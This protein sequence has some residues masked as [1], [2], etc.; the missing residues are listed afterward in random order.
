M[1]E[2]VYQWCVRPKLHYV[3]HIGLM[4]E[5]M[6]PKASWAYRGEAMVGSVSSLAHSCLN[7]TAPHQVPSAV[8]AKYM[9]AKHLQFK[10]SI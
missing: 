3:A 4:A 5:W 6:S 1:G 8:C 10:F 2:W 7:N 9:L